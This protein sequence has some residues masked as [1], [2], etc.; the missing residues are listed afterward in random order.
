M[1]AQNQAHTQAQ[2]Q[3]QVQK[4]VSSLDDILSLYRQL[5]DVM[6]KE[7]DLLIAAD[8]PALDEN[9]VQKEELLMKLKLADAA[10]IRSATDLAKLIGADSENPRLLEISQRLGGAGGDK[11]RSQHSALELVIKR[12]V[13]LNRENEEYAQS[14][15]KALQGAMGDIK[16]TITGKATYERK[17][18]YKMGPQVAGNF[19]SKEA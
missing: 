7:K 17:G 13:E 12:I 9:N 3:R 14:A 8:R 5:L 1:E 4:L 19:V 6:R 16:E 11:L 10:R 15:L 2:I 18:Q